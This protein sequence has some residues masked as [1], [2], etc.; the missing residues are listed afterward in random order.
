VQGKLP[1]GC[2]ESESDVL[3]KSDQAV[4]DEKITFQIKF[5]NG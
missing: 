5:V 4:S 1:K 2:L 3:V